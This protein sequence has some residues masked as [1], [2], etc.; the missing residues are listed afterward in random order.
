MVEY[1][2][3]RMPSANRVYG[4]Q[5][6]QLALAE[7]AATTDLVQDQ[8]LHHIA[9]IEYVCCE[10]PELDADGLRRIAAQSSCFALF[11][12]REDALVPVQLPTPFVLDDDLVTIPKYPGKTNEHFTQLLLN[13]TLAA[14]TRPAQGPRRILDPMAG[15]G[16]TLSTALRAGHHGFG[17]ERDAKALDAMV[18]FYKTYL[19]RRRIKHSVQVAALRR[20]GVNLGRRFTGTVTTSAG[21]L[22]L[23]SMT[24]DATASRELYGKKKFD[25]IVTDAPYGVEHAATAGG[26]RD[27]S[28]AQ[29]LRAAIPVWSGQLV[30]GGALGISWNTFGLTRDDLAEIITGAGL[31]VLDQGGFSHRVD[32]SIRRDLIVATKP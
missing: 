27:R 14:I 9:G 30:H 32:S 5:S 22:S 10:A 6:G 19:R 8:R 20:D 28:P 23:E 7:L 24:G 17:I 3:L 15:R 1:L 13:V 4:E 11:R 12:H 16:T 21:E 2:M 29:L 18:A 25:A 26:H 31:S